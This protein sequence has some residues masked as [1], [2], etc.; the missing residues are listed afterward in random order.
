MPTLFL[1][2]IILWFFLALL[3]IVFS[4]RK[5]SAIISLVAF[6]VFFMASMPLAVV[7]TEASRFSLGAAWISGLISIICFIILERA[8]FERS[9]ADSMRNKL[10]ENVGRLRDFAESGSDVF[11]ET[12][13]ELRFIF[14]SDFDTHGYI[15][16][17]GLELGKTLWDCHGIRDLDD[18][19][20]E[21]HIKQQ[22]SKRPFRNF[23]YSIS[24][25]EG[26]V[27]YWKMGGSPAYNSRGEFLGFRGSSSDVTPEFKAQEDA[28]QAQA[29]LIDA[30]ENINEGFA[31]WDKEDKLVLCNQRYREMCEGFEDLLA[32]GTP[33]ETLFRA[34]LEHKSVLLESGE[35]IESRVARRLKIRQDPKINSFIQRYSGDRW[36][37]ITESKLNDGG[38]AI[39][40]TDVTK[41]KQKELDL[42][43]AVKMEAVGQLSGGLAHDFNNLL[44]VILGNLELLSSQV[45]SG[46]FQERL[47]GRAIQGGK[48]ASAITKRLLTFSR[49][50]ALS[51]EVTNFSSLISGMQELLQSSVGKGIYV[52]TDLELEPWP[53]IL[54]VNAFETILMNLALNARDAMPDGGTLSIRVK[55]CSSENILSS[56]RAK[57]KEEN[58]LL[59]EVSDTGIGM[60]EDVAGQCFDPFF[61]TKDSSKG[62]GLG[63][64]MVSNFVHESSGEV[65]LE[66]ELDQ[67]TTIFIY[68][69]RVEGESLPSEQVEE[70]SY[71]PLGRGERVLVVEDNVDVREL[72]LNMLR[73]LAY[74]TVAVESAE[75]A[76]RMLK[77][78][79]DIDILLTD[80]MLL[81]GGNGFEL[82]D[83]ARKIFPNFPILFMTGYS[84]RLDDKKYPLI[85]NVALLQKPFT[86]RQLAM[87][88]KEM[89]LKSNTSSRIANVS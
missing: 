45:D 25:K 34:A 59:V 26:E 49:K 32:P 30:L 10:R 76:I 31:Y 66:S 42:L 73:S 15:N 50:P 81:D 71:C 19:K 74:N 52:E 43:Q 67:G 51:P 8:Y 69:P 80:I 89:L 20:W 53:V 61:T 48:R 36:L 82:A 16:R 40:C 27:T 4:L 54:D 63:L 6:L 60:Q 64:S 86:R 46:S 57:L 22:K 35:D 39:V 88:L 85:K 17:H 84:E 72:T 29:R 7:A 24:S 28:A 18:P 44:A 33:F 2:L 58:Y 56:H 9:S 70:S 5:N 79:T 38:I 21:R 68:L 37:Q 47:V 14:I 23:Y 55:N 87:G 62:S 12:D 11:W 78:D 41:L 75:Q 3:V 83:E 1:S 77:K 65:F 13:A